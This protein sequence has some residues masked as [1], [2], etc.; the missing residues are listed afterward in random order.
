MA[1]NG[2][3]GFSGD[4]GAATSAQ[5]YHPKGVALTAGGNL[6]IADTQNSRV[7]VVT[8]NGTISTVA[9]NG[10]F[11]YSGDGGAAASAELSNPYA[12][13]Q[14]AAG[15][16][17]IA[18]GAR[19]RA[20]SAPGAII[21]TNAGDGAFDYSGDNG[22]AASAGF[23][24]LTGA[25][26]I[27]AAD[28]YNN[29]I[30]MLTLAGG[31][32]LLNLNGTHT[33]N[34]N[35][36]K[37]G[38]LTLTVNNAPLAGSTKGAVTVTDLA[39]TGTDLVSMSGA[40]WSCTGAVCS[41]SDALA[42]G[43]SHPPITVAV[44]ATS[45]GPGMTVNEST[46]SGGGSVTTGSQDVTLIVPA[47]PVVSPANG[48]IDVSLGAALSWTAS[49][50]ANA[51]DVYFGVSPT[52][53]LAASTVLASYNPGLVMGNTKYYWQVTAKN[54]A[55]TASTS[56]SFTTQPCTYSLSPSGAV[57]SASGG[58]GSFS[59]TTSGGCQWI[60]STYPISWLIVTSGVGLGNGSVSY[61]IA[62]NPTGVPRSSTI[63]VGGQTFTVTQAA[64]LS[65]LFSLSS[66]SASLNNGSGTFTS[67][68]GSFAVTSSYCSPADTWTATSDSPRLTITS[69]ASGGGVPS[70]TIVAFSM[71]TNST[72]LSQTAH[73][74]VN[75]TMSGLPFSMMFTVTQAGST[76]PQLQR[77][78][79]ALYQ[80]ILGREP[81]PSGWAFW[82]GPAVPRASNGVA[83][84]NV[85]A[86]DFYR[87]AEFQGNGFAIFSIYGA[88]LGR[89]PSF[90]E[91]SAGTLS[92]RN[93][94]Q[95]PA[96][97]VDGL[98]GAL[99][100]A[101]FVQTA[102]I[103]GLGR[104]ATPAEISAYS[105][106]LNGGET[107]YDFLNSVIFP[108]AAFQNA[109]NGAFVAM[110]YYTI[111]VRDFDMAGFDFWL[112]VV[113]TPPGQGGIYYLFNQPAAPYALKLEVI[114]QAV[115]PNPNLLGF[116]GGPEFQRLIQ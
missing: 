61:S 4:G 115:P 77:V 70:I 79:R 13:A 21:T 81:D 93:L 75:G 28:G 102:I 48:A 36:G 26:N 24:F 110:L 55:G 32:A 31:T 111:L 116:L 64:V 5:L 114:G 50:Q 12:I 82:T 51:Y 89:L 45:A 86:D 23:Q 59:V 3:P 60:A 66:S 109:T 67:V 33:G 43:A 76:E 53:P 73:M 101:A 41:R 99:S 18:D 49:P 11:G 1:G 30:R 72:T 22:L 42:G 44:N 108:N 6:Y 103:N 68:A 37:Q 40:G 78:V 15:N 10:T 94:T 56:G 25:G 97:V 8:A 105:A 62:P 47:P 80:T 96:Q 112:G 104:A 52:P 19:I 95:T 69:G 38:A 85:M 83:L 84:V 29:A 46:V 98:A 90:A 9:G 20:V 71:L 113:N 74:V 39:P 87:S 106:Q 107:K 91:W 54:T 16:L 92:L 34:L 58:M 27:Y 57:F 35:A 7:R 100:N 63:A 2:G 65:C 14:D 17:Y 88:V